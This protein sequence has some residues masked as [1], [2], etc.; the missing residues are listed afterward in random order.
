MILSFKRHYLFD[1]ETPTRFMEKIQAGSKIHS[2]RLG[3]RWRAGLPIDFWEESPRN[4]TMSPQEFTIPTDRAVVWRHV[5]RQ[6]KELFLPHCYKTEPFILELKRL[7]D[8]DGQINRFEASL[9]IG[10]LYFNTPELFNLVATND[11]F[12]SATEFCRWFA[13]YIPKGHNSFTFR[14][15]VVHWTDQLYNPKPA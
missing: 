12:N 15:V 14:G 8:A 13:E 1:K 9:K 2:F 11:G 7:P 5:N 10:D 6:G 4:Q 3:A